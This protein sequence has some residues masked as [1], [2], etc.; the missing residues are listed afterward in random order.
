LKVN[1]TGDVS[2]TGEFKAMDALNHLQAGYCGIVQRYPFQ[3]PARGGMNWSMDGCGCNVL[4]GWFMVD[5]I[6]YVGNQLQAVDLRFSQLCDGAIAP[7]RGRVRWTLTGLA[8]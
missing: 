1:L 3:N 7:L 4:S 6:S 8:S 2:G 5:S